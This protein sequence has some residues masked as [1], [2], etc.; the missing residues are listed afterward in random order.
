[1]KIRQVKESDNPHLSKMIRKVFEEHDAPKNGT[2]YSDPTTNYLYESF[3]IEKSVL[4][5]AENN[6][7]ILG[8][9]GVYPTTG[10][11]KQCV[12]LVKF[13]LPKESRGKGI[14]KILMEKSIDWAEKFGYSEVYIESL[15]QF[16]KA[17]NM[18]QKQGFIK[19][20]NPLGTSGHTSCN[21]W[22]LKKL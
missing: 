12:E 11:P 6:N 10:L 2:V 22:M 18:Y 14:G 1:M 19:L 7:K 21:I 16:S 13:Y 3:Q 20:N 5:V 9:C 17:I 15:P 4:W 8:C